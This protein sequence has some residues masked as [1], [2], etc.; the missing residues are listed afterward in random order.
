MSTNVTLVSAC[1]LCPTMSEI[2]VAYRKRYCL[3]MVIAVTTRAGRPCDRACSSRLEAMRLVT[4]LSVS[5]GLERVES[6]LTQCQLRYQHHN[7]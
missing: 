7:I 4:N 5:S 3:S 6:E 1:Q 2:R